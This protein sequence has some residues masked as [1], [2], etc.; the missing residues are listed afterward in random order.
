MALSPLSSCTDNKL[1]LMT[2]TNVTK[3]Y[4]RKKI[5]EIDDFEIFSGDKIEI[6]GINASGKSTLLRL[7]VGITPKSGGSIYR[8]AEMNTL[9]L[10]Y[11]PQFGGNHPHLT[12]KEN[13]RLM[14][15]L[16]G[17]TSALISKDSRFIDYFQL[18]RY[19]DTQLRHLSGG[20]QKIACLAIALS[21]RP[22]ALFL[23]EPLSGVDDRRRALI[24]EAIDE[25]SGDRQL[26][27]I[28]GHS[29]KEAFRCNRHLTINSGELS[30]P[31][32]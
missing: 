10:G 23:D 25:F 8:S 31:A 20:L 3:Y 32:Q 18:H 12:I 22:E 21:L 14:A 4:G 19:L 30:C 24:H 28:T 6:T 5:L 29:H 26:V 15:K 27:V 16:F 11:V 1:P 13:F 2:L 17:H 9:L 7:L